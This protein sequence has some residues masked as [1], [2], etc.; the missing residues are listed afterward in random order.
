MRRTTEQFLGLLV[1]IILLVGVATLFIGIFP[2]TAHIGVDRVGRHVDLPALQEALLPG[3][4]DAQLARILACGSRVPGQPGLSATA[5]LIR[6]TFSDAGLD[7]Y[8]QDVEFATVLT[9][10]GAG[11]LRLAGDATE[12]AV[13][14]LAPNYVQPV[15]TPSS[16]VSGELVVISKKIM[17]TAKSF[18][19]KIAVIDLA[20]PELYE[21]GIEPALFAELGFEAI[22]YTHSDGMESII[23]SDL[24]RLF[25]EF[26]PANVVRVVVAPEVLAL[27]G[28]GATLTVQSKW[29]NTR[30]RNIIGRL[31]ASQPAESALVIPVYYDAL[32][33][34]PDLAP[35]TYQAL[36]TAILLQV[37]E[38]LRDHRSVL[39]R[40]VIF[41]AATGVDSKQH[42]MARIVS[43][44]GQVGKSAVA[45]ER[46][47]ADLAGQMGA[48]SELEEMLRLFDEPSFSTVEGIESSRLALA[49]ISE[50]AQKRFAVQFN[51]LMRMRVF[52]YAETLLEAEIAFKR[53]PE[54]LNGP[55]YLAFRKAKQT[56][57]DYNTLSSLSFLRFLS[58]PQAK[59]SRFFCAPETLALDPD[60]GNSLRRALQG[61]FRMLLAYHESCIASLNRDAAL[62]S[63]LSAYSNLIVVSPAFNPDVRRTAVETIGFTS[64]TTVTHGVAAQA[65]HRLLED[66]DR[67]CGGERG[68]IIRA[69]KRSSSFTSELSSEAFRMAST[70]WALASH[71]TFSIISPTSSYTDVGDRP[72]YVAPDLMALERAFSVF[73][74]VILAC[75]SGDGNFKRLNLVTSTGYQ[76]TVFAAGVG[77]SIIPNFPVAGALIATGSKPSLFTDPYGSFKVDLGIRRRE[78]DFPFFGSLQ[79]YCFDTNGFITHVKDFGA[80]AS[81]IYKSERTSFTARNNIIMYRAA[82]VAIFD[83]VNPQSM[84]AFTDATFITREG[85]NSF[86]S[87][88]AFISLVG[89]MDFIPPEKRFFV[90]LR[91]GSADNE[92]V[93]VVRA[94]CLGT[95]MTNDPAY[96]PDPDAEIDGPG[97]L[98]YDTPVLRNV[99]HE[100]SASMADLANDRLDLQKRFG[101]ADEMTLA[102]HQRAL[103]TME[104]AG[105]DSFSSAESHRGFREALA[106][107]ILNQPVIHG[108]ISEA[109]WGILW[110]MALI[111]PFMFFFEK[112]VFGFTDIRKQLLAQGLIFLTV[113]LLLRLLHPAFQIVRSSL[114]ILLGFVIILIAGSATVLLSAKFQENIDALRRAQGAVKNAEG[115]RFGMMATAFMLGLNNMHRRKVRT[116]LTCASLVL[117]TFVMICFSSVQSN[118]VNRNRAVGKALYQGLLVRTQRFTPITEREIQALK[119][120]YGHAYTLS[121]RAIMPGTY[122]PDTKRTVPP[123][124]AVTA[125]EGDQA[126]MRN[127]RAAL[128]FD[129]TEPLGAAIPL[130]TTNGWFTTAQQNSAEGAMPMILSDRMADKLHISIDA[131]HTGQPSVSING[132]PFFVQGIFD[133]SLFSRVH[134]VDE[135]NLLP[136]DIEALV[137]PRIQGK[138]II[139]ADASDARV[140]AEDVILVLNG[141]LAP[142]DPTGLRTVSTVVDMQVADYPMARR[143]INAYLEQTTRQTCYGL[144]GIGYIAR[145]AR[146]RSLGGLID[147][148]IPLVIAGLTVLNT[149]KGSVYE[150]RGEIFVY[151]A[152]GIAPRHVFFMFVAEALVYAVVGIMLGYVLAQGTGRILTELNLT[153]GLNMNFTSLSTVYASLAIAAATVLST[154]F[155]ARSAM[156]IAKPADDSGWRLPTS[157]GDALSFN[158]PFTFG[159]RDRIAVLGFFHTYFVNHGEGSSGPFSAGKPKLGI[160]EATDAVEKDAYVPAIAVTIWCKPYDLGVS[161][162]IQIALEMDPETGEYIS[163]MTLNRLTGTR[164]A[165]LR[166]NGPLVTRIRQHFL[167]WRAAS[168]DM[169]EEFF[170]KAKALIEETGNFRTEDETNG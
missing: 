163:K 77:T 82:P 130:L 43:T 14:P 106:Y 125:G 128:L 6:K 88:S 137:S 21:I 25:F 169:K 80:A 135:E 95:T 38:G 141:H 31:R 133:S 9:D 131:V 123:V 36:Q 117:M 90:T 156:E 148:I 84:K 7:V 83:F 76:G 143:E 20:R 115:N 51:T 49:G 69:P 53:D 58:R 28:Q 34:I 61:R 54:E 85:L 119:E 107:L 4:V 113:F 64:G 147:L 59:G 37:V 120:R 100:A 78:N 65:F 8:E 121:I 15:V 60:A 22:L 155:P 129:A 27:D 2:P 68:I 29:R 55:A 87:T 71:P 81:L 138:N 50:E 118:I 73:G 57:D 12:L 48:K 42:G 104:A 153:G 70:A 86:P 17:E 145:R 132:R 105:S 16:G 89:L 56:Y 75:A 160:R 166:L 102:F 18:K 24:R 92:L 142:T 103:K 41:V 40:D 26:F 33:L 122:D 44:L 158:L 134:D 139:L 140:A 3:S 164:D 159:R 144:D 114:M 52:K 30:T 97:Y 116:G 93:S 162:R 152:V 32:S 126:V 168:E 127:A 10:G 94:F 124:I 79:A 111:V 154:W 96:K 109:I 157:E 62:H 101:M 72:F 39:K 112:L 5:D 149:M 136:F 146:T 150:R 67:R 74:E 110:Y 11:V 1:F 167:H 47:T 165:W 45:G 170:V 19:G 161:Q 23:S 35:G 66:A 99:S 63:L 98:A 91:A 13:Y 46:I 108:A 151:N